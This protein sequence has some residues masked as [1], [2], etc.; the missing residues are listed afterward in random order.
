MTEILSTTG[1]HSV[2]IVQDMRLGDDD[3]GLVQIEVTKVLL[4]RLF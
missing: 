4:I 1:F 3:P 2:S